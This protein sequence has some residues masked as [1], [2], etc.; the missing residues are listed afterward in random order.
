MMFFKITKAYFFCF[1]L[2]TATINSKEN[3]LSKFDIGSFVGGIV[4][5]L[6]ICRFFTLD[7]KCVIQEEAFG[8]EP[9]EF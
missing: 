8:M 4:L 9:C 3:T 5:T 1:L 6:E 7:A 2:I